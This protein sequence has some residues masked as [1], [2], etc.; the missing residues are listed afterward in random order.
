MGFTRITEEDIKNKGVSGLPDTPNLSVSEMQAKFEE[1]ETDVIIPKFNELVDE[2]ES[3]TAAANIGIVPPD[4]FT[5]NTVQ[6][7][8][9]EFSETLNNVDDAKHSHSNKVV[10]DR[11]TAPGN[12]GPDGHLKY[13][14]ECVVM[15]NDLKDGDSIIVERQDNMYRMTIK[16]KSITDDML[17]T[18]FAKVIEERATELSES[19]S[20]LESEVA[21]TYATKEEVADSLA[22]LETEV[23]KTYATKNELSTE[24]MN[25]YRNIMGQVV[26][27]A[28]DFSNEAASGKADVIL[29]N[30]QGES[31]HLT[32]STDSKAVEFALIGKATQNGTPTPD[33]PIDITIS[34]ADGSVEVISENEDGTK[35]SSATVSTPNG[36]A[37]INGVCDEKRVYAD[38][39]GQYI[40]RIEKAVFDG[41]DDEYW[42]ASAGG[43]VA[44]PLIRGKVK[45]PQDTSIVGNTLCNIATKSSRINL[46]N[47][48][49]QIAI[50]SDSSV[51][52][53]SLYGNDVETWKSYLASNPM[54][55][56]YELAEPIITDL[57]AEEIAELE[58]VETFYPTTNILNDAGCGMEITFKADTKN[59]IDR[60]I[61]ERISAIETALIN[62]I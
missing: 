56:W 3:G 36:L 60:I 48:L 24:E 50:A 13:N 35:S 19:I 23:A 21:N 31:I 22:E 61:G 5:G 33:T 20:E 7:L 51:C 30:A 15:D 2:L 29:A 45:V 53:Y 43:F 57:T 25:L 37:G 1:L 6:G 10:I 17:V 58:A 27:I 11:F 18:D 59:Y 52:I 62:N 46:T 54:T 44:S 39:T 38:G 14:N 4:G 9:D 8:V 42:Y 47:K 49:N 34:G 28:E 26:E 12:T 32:D 16:P 55:V 41:S 40:Q